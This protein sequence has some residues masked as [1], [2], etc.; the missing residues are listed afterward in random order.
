MG[1]AC[2]GRSGQ[3]PAVRRDALEPEPAGVVA[4]VELGRLVESLRHPEQAAPLVQEL[5]LLAAQ[6]VTREHRAPVRE[7][8]L[9]VGRPSLVGQ[10]H[11][12]GERDD[13]GP[14]SPVLA[15]GDDRAEAVGVLS[16]LLYAAELGE[17]TGEVGPHPEFEV[18]RAAVDDDVQRGLQELDRSRPLAAERA[19]AGTQVAGRPLVPAVAGPA[20]GLERSSRQARRL[21]P[22][23]RPRDRGRV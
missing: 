11:R 23:R 12:V 6:A 1:L 20:A 15:A 17:R 19:Y 16:R 14:S 8:A 7:D 3:L 22:G 21:P 5:G 2:W 10:D 18:R 9:G 13:A 4:P